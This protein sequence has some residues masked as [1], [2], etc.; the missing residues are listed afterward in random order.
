MTSVER[1]DG[2]PFG[3]GSRVRIKQPGFP[4]VEW[5]VHRFDLGRAFSWRATSPGLTTVAE[6][7]IEPHGD[8]SRVTLAVRQTG[9]LAGPLALLTSARTR[10]YVEMEAGGLKRRVEG[11]G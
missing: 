8:G 7:R 9:P 6:H 10:R 4:K 3:L 5:E 1:V 2:E 11:G